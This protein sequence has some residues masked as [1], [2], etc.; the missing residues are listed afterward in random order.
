VFSFYG[1]FDPE[2]DN[3]DIAFS[4]ALKLENG[5]DS[6][7]PPSSN[8]TKATLLINFS[9]ESD[10]PIWEAQTAL[11]GSMN[12]HFN[13]TSSGGETHAGSKAVIKDIKL[14]FIN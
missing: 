2:S 14:E 4:W 9:N 3:S 6:N 7:L 1:S 13:V 12:F 5:D 10:K 8:Y 11:K